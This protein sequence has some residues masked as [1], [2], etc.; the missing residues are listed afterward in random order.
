VVHGT[1]LLAIKEDL[2]QRMLATNNCCLIFLARDSNPDSPFRGGLGRDDRDAYPKV[3]VITTGFLWQY[4]EARC[5][6]P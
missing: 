5:T 2:F 1:R 4:S 6:L 3:Q